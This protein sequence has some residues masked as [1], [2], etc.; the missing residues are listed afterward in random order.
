MRW[1]TRGEKDK[2]SHRSEGHRW[3][4]WYWVRLETGEAASEDSPKHWAWLEFVERQ[5][6]CV[7][8]GPHGFWW[9][10]TYRSI[11]QEPRET[12]LAK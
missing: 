8:G 2:Y 10:H 9:I 7:G 6:R 5:T 1:T 11:E 12:S 4:A 3:F